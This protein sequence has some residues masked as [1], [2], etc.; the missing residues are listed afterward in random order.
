MRAR[1]GTPESFADACYAAV[2]GYISMSEANA[3]IERYI[4]R[5]SAA[6]ESDGT[7]PEKTPVQP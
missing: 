5:Y 7:D 4:R 1:H 2:P 3:A 6:P